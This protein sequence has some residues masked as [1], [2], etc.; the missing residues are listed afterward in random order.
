MISKDRKRNIG[1]RES[2]RVILIAYEGKNKTEK[3]YFNGFKGID[4]DYVIKVVPGNETDPVNLVKQTIQNI[5]DLGLTL[6]DDDRAFCVFDTDT[7][8]QKNSQIIEAITIAN[9][10]NIK[11]ITSSPCFETWFLLHFEFTTASMTNNNV[12]SRLQGHYSKYTKN[13]SMYPV[14]VDKTSNAYTNAIK[15]EKYQKYNNKNVKLVEANP[16][17]DV[18]KIIDE[19]IKNKV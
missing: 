7:N 19:L 2:K 3:N 4:K 1:N 6:E 17:T 16:H 13:C 18:Y 14:I 11:V 10:K 5:K 9:N 15:L 12:I 8:S